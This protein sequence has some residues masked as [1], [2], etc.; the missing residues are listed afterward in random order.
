M[1][2][3]G[4]GV[5]FYEY[6]KMKSNMLNSIK[7]NG[8]FWIGRYETGAQ[9]ATKLNKTRNSESG[10]DDEAVIQANKIPYNYVTCSQAQELAKKMNK[11]NEYTTSLLFGIQWDLVCKFLEVRGILS[12]NDIA[13]DSSKWG[14]YSNT[15]I[16]LSRGKYN[17]NPGDK[18]SVWKNYNENTE[19]YIINS[20]SNKNAEYFQLI[21]KRDSEDTKVMNIYDFAGNVWE[22]TMEQSTEIA[23][24]STVCV[25]RGGY[26]SYIGSHFCASYRNR[27]QINFM[28]D[29]FGFRIALY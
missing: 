1:L 8:G 6:Y 20:Q 2:A 9:N 24:R 17:I 3:N 5:S 22:W 21:L 19:G 13:N 25:C 16:N 18:D 12:T 10:T 11:S 7:D 26:F 14:N 4:C 27:Y 28:Y 29:N 23:N 15:K